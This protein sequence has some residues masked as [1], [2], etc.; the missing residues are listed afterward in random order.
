MATILNNFTFTTKVDS[1]KEVSLKQ[2]EQLFGVWYDPKV[3]ERIEKEYHRK[4]C[5]RKLAEKKET[6]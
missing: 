2:R 3:I 1:T 4:Q 5:S 6:G